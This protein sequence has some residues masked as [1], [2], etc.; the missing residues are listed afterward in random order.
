MKHAIEDK[1]ILYF[2]NAP[3]RQFGS[4]LRVFIDFLKIAGV[5]HSL[6]FSYSGSDTSLLQDLTIEENIVLSINNNMKDV[7]HVGY[8]HKY[9]KNL[10]NPFLLELYRDLSRSCHLSMLPGQITDFTAKK[11]LIIKA[12]LQPCR[13]IILEHNNINLDEQTLHLLQKA[14]LFTINS[15]NKT[16]LIA[17]RHPGQ[18]QKVATKYVQ[19]AS[20][21]KSRFDIIPHFE[22]L[23]VDDDS[24]ILEFDHSLKKIAS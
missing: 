15:E 19:F 11:A 1:D 14:L 2:T 8:L 4:N 6:K 16:A 9:I 10:K 20:N 21:H 7:K 23:Q 5:D 22:W 18:W 12:L 13:F 24:S 17:D 3:F